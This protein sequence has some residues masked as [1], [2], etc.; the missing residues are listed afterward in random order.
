LDDDSEGGGGFGSHYADLTVGGK[1]HVKLWL[2]ETEEQGNIQH[3]A[4]K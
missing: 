2:D 1:S 3:R 4:T